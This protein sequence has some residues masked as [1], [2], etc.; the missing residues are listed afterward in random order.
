MADTATALEH[1]SLP[2]IITTGLLL[3]FVHVLTGPD[4]LS[5]LIVL[6]AGSSWRSCQLGMR[7]G[8][9]HSTGLI[10][11]TAIFLALN[12]QLDVDTFGSYCDFMVGFLMMGLGLWSLRYYLLLRRK[13]QQKHQPAGERTPLQLESQLRSEEDSASDTEV[14]KML[15]AHHLDH[16]GSSAD[17]KMD[18]SQPKTCCFGLIKG[19]IKNP[20]TQKITAFAYGTAHGLAGTGGVLGVLPAV[21]LNDWIKSSA[22]LGAFCVSSIIAMGGFAALYGEVTGRMSRFSDSSL[23]RVGIFSSCVSL[24]VGI[25]WVILV[26]TGT[27]DEVFG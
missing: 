7:W 10:V 27:L 24:V 11:V 16:E 6:S 21:I 3:G 19:D 26:S 12:Q 13:L 23:M 15:H 4:H 17:A 22:Y 9:G 5:A 25:M 18:P 2:G 8:C 1:A 20:R 14:Q